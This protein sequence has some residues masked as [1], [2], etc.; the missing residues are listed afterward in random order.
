[1]IP[2]G[3]SGMIL[4]LVFAGVMN[5]GSWWFSDKI[6]LKLNRARPVT[7]EEAPDLHASIERLARKAGMPKPKVCLV[8]DPAPNAFAT[9]RNPAH[10]VVAATT[11]L[12]G[13]MSRDEVEGV[14]AHEL[15]HIK[16]RDTLVMAIAATIA[17]A[18]MMI[19]SMLRWGLIFGGIGGGGRGRG[20]NPFAMIIMIIVAPLAAML[21][22]MAISRSREFGADRGAKEIMG[23]PMPLVS[24]LR[25]LDR[26]A[27]EIPMRHASPQTAHLY[28]VNPFRGGITK[29][30][31]THPP[32]EARIEHLMNG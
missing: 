10:G 30:F 28:I 16:N 19:A 31:S 15:S 12:I 23:T 13:M 18:I 21:I 20:T 5:V 22:Q 24:A 3:R 4:A 8:E 9:G 29:L 2:G 25:K 32:V 6:V 26:G 1:M 14:L 11:G 27:K 7:P 17:G